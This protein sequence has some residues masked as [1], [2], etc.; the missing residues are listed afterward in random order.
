M[1]KHLLTGVEDISKHDY[2]RK[3]LGTGPFVV[4]DFKAGDS[5]TVERNPNYR[6]KDK[7]YLDKLIF[8]SVPSSQVAIAQLKAGEVQ[9]MWNLVESEAAEV[10]KDA[11]GQ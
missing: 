9:G 3:P 1:P 11:H 7:P 2:N 5:I 4:T 6:V 8:K 10:E